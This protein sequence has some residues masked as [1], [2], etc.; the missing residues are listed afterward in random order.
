VQRGAQDLLRVRLKDFSIRGPL[1]RHDGLDAA[2]AEGRHYGE[3]SARVL[4]HGPDDALPPGRTPEPPRHGQVDA[5][6]IDKFEALEIERLNQ[7]VAVLPRLLDP[8]GVA[9]RRMER[10][11]SRGTPKRCTS[12][13]MVGKLTRMPVMSAAR[14]HNS[15]KV[16]SGWSRTSGWT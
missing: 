11:F 2:Q 9:L 3:M 7:R 13:H 14:M 8:L 6:F 15:S 16:A 5:R 10:L 4:W 12:R 1:D